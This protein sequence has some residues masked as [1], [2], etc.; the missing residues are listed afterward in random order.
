MPKLKVTLS[1]GYSGATHEDVLEIE[2]DE[3]VSCETD[4]E[5]EKLIDD[6]WG[7]W[8][9]NYIDGSAVIVD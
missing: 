8:A 1:I 3:W 5:R 2:D 6:Y 4:E 9:N 7:D